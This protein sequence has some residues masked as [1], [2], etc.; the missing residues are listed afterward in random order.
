MQIS[1]SATVCLV[2]LVIKYEL[3]R[4][5]EALEPLQNR[6]RYSSDHPQ[7]VTACRYGNINDER[8]MVSSRLRCV[9]KPVNCRAREAAV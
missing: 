5:D 1:C 7:T 3:P 8:P 4:R 6:F 9:T 2:V